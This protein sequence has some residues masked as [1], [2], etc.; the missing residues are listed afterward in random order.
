MAI[1]GQDIDISD[2]PC[3][4]PPR[5]RDLCLARRLAAGCGDAVPRARRL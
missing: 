1:V 2:P 5:S 4:V 3:V